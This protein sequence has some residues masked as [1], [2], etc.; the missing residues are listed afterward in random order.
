MAVGLSFMPPAWTIFPTSDKVLIRRDETPEYYDK[1]KMLLRP[2]S[3]KEREKSLSGIVAATGPDVTNT[4]L[5]PGA[6]VIFGEYAGTNISVD[7]IA[8]VVMKEADIHVV[9][10]ER[11]AAEDGPG[12]PGESEK[13]APEAV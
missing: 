6:T 1:A 8:F 2:A 10:E 9:L 5:S 4:L 11:D 12:V 3:Y 7:G 13:T